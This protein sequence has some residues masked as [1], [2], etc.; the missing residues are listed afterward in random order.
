MTLV[1]IQEGGKG[2]GE[3]RSSEGSPRIMCGYVRLLLL[4]KHL[5]DIAGVVNPLVKHFKQNHPF[6]CGKEC[7]P[8]GE[9]FSNAS[10][11]EGWH[12]VLPLLRLCFFMFPGD[13]LF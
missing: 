11:A 1:G 12:P 2:R 8:H 3:G 5:S 13:A 7:C 6:W 10:H 4:A 9:H